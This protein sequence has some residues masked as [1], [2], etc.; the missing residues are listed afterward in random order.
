MAAIVAYHAPPGGYL[1]G[2]HPLVTRFL[3]GVLR[4][5][6]REAYA[7]WWIRMLFHSLKSSDL[8]SPLGVKAHSNRSVA[9][10]K[11]F[12][13]C[14]PMQDICNA[15]GWSKPLTFLGSMT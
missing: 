8:P 5:L 6:A 14:V 3:R 11:S 7:M 10:S 4:P 1:V 15:V 2:S 12:L 9:A 13:A